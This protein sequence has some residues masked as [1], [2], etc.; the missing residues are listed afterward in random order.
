[1]DSA[2][3]TAKQLEE[4]G[5]L[6]KGTAFRMAKAG[7]LAHYKIGTAGRGIR[8]RVDEVLAALRQP[9]AEGASKA[10]VGR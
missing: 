1:M 10:T 4:I 2:L 7:L 6:K 3:V 9:A 5:V 8:F